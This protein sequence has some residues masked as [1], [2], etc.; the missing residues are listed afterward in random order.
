MTL[1]TGGR[2]PAFFLSP[3]TFNTV[4][5]THDCACN[6]VGDTT[7]ANRKSKIPG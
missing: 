3:K 1:S 5:Y 2:D 7:L 4:P 6:I